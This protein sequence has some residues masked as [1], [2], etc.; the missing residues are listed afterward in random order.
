M[1]DMCHSVDTKNRKKKD[2]NNFT[3]VFTELS[4]AKRRE[5]SIEYEFYRLSSYSRPFYQI[6]M[7]NIS[8]WQSD[9][10]QDIIKF[11]CINTISTLRYLNLKYRCRL[12][13]SF[14]RPIKLDHAIFLFKFIRLYD[15]TSVTLSLF[16]VFL[17]TVY[18][19]S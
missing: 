5:H 9:K 8:L 4:H 13:N 19:Y 1:S 7:Y 15:S 18:R 10:R 11:K 12:R 17:Y 16:G 3:A 14:Q 2:F 6:Y